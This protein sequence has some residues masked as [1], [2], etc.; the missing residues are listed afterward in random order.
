[1]VGDW[2][3]P[4]KQEHLEQLHFRIHEK[5][6]APALKALWSSEDLGGVV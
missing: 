1:M 6:V 4:F 5:N 3:T 2:K